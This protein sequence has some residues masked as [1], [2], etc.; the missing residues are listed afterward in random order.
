IILIQTLSGFGQYAGRKF[1]FQNEIL[2]FI[3]DSLLDF[4]FISNGCLERTLRGVGKYQ[5]KGNQLVIQTVR[6]DSIKPYKIEQQAISPET[7]S[8]TIYLRFANNQIPISNAQYY[9]LDSTFK[10]LGLGYADKKGVI[11]IKNDLGILFLNI[12]NG[13]NVNVSFKELYGKISF[14][15]MTTIRVLE[16]EKLLFDFEVSGNSICLTGPLPLP[17][18]R[19]ENAKWKRRIYLSMMTNSWPWNWSFRHNHIHDPK[20]HCLNEI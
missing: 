12:Y 5:I 16:N 3:N 1:V 15:S 14:I 19:K 18:N 20:R 8:T 2:A 11:H 9:L 6:Q 10:S 17:E 7:D 4:T 13:N